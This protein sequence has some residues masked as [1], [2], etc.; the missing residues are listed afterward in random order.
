MKDKCPH[1]YRLRLNGGRRLY[2]CCDLKGGFMLRD[3]RCC[4]KDCPLKQAAE[5][6]KETL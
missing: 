3:W 4:E 2:R 5:A 6:A 1:L